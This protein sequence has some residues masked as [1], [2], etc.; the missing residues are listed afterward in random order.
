MLVEQHT[1]ARMKSALRIT[2]LAVLFGA[3]YSTNVRS[4]ESV[5]KSEILALIVDLGHDSYTRRMD[6]TSRLD[7]VGL[8]SV[9]PL[10][11]A[12]VDSDR[13]VATRALQ[14]L[15]RL[16]ATS[17][18]SYDLLDSEQHEHS[19][20][21][22]VA[23]R[24]VAIKSVRDAQRKRNIKKVNSRIVVARN[25]IGRKNWKLVA[26]R[27]SEARKFAR[28]HG[29]YEVFDHRFVEIEVDATV[30]YGDIPPQ[31]SISDKKQRAM[32]LLSSAM[33]S[34]DRSQVLAARR[35]VKLA[36]KLSPPH[37][38][39]GHMPGNVEFRIRQKSYSIAIVAAI[40][41]TGK[42]AADMMMTQRFS[43]TVTPRIII[44]EEQE[45]LLGIGR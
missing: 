7:A 28:R 30:K 15:I 11:R 21:G 42:P 17:N 5:S 18:E 22:V 13:E 1:C 6:A 19:A 8:R 26:V 3:L 14:I 20:N 9:K 36:R 16:A 23:K 2:V 32:I 40:G 10:L 35:F 29:L 12:A 27:I 45:E 39:F 44:H 37:S 41:I 43:I 34:L 4:A 24:V 31:F 38:P 25:A 33:R